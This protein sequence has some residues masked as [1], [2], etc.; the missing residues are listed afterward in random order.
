MAGLAFTPGGAL[1]KRTGAEEFC[2]DGGVLLV[3]CGSCHI[4]HE[5]LA[6]IIDFTLCAV[7]VAAGSVEGEIDRLLGDSEVEERKST[8]SFGVISFYQA[9]RGTIPRQ[10]DHLVLIEVAGGV[11]CACIL[12]L[13]CD[14]NR[15]GSSTCDIF[16]ADADTEILSFYVHD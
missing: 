14:V 16:T 2:R 5:R 13:L 10:A 9:V 4:V 12:C 8:R 3:L 15:T 6:A 1:S 7:L 11:L